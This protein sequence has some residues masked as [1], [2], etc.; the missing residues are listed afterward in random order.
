[1]RKIDDVMTM[2]KEECRQTVC[3]LQGDLEERAKQ[4]H[5]E[6]N[7]MKQRM[8]EGIERVFD[9]ARRGLNAASAAVGEVLYAH[10][11]TPITSPIASPLHVSPQPA[12]SQASRRT[13]AA[14]AAAPGTPGS[15]GTPAKRARTA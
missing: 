2:T 14:A 6:I 11:T 8:L 5:G 9:T 10:Q 13:R 4:V 3:R 15:L 12:A 1:M 7:G